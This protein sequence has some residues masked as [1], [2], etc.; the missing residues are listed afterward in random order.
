MLSLSLIYIHIY[1]YRYIYIYIYLFVYLLYSTS[2]I[3]EE[4]ICKKNL[5]GSNSKAKKCQ[6][7]QKNSK[8]AVN[9]KHTCTCAKLSYVEIPACYL[10]SQNG[11]YKW[12]FNKEAK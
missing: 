6:T 12:L 1:I 3:S 2:E 4:V 5:L 9:I 10:I 11:S 8:R 7:P